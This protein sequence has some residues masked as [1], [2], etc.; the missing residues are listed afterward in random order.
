MSGR[1]ASGPA[2][3]LSVQHR[4]HLILAVFVLIVCAGSAVG[5]F[6]LSRTSDRTTELVDRIQPARSSSFQLQN[7]LLD[8]ETGVRGFALTGDATF[9]RP[10]EQGM[11][12]ESLQLARVRAL[13]GDEQPF[14]DDLDRIAAAAREWRG[15]HAEP[16]VAAVRRDGP[17][18]ESS[19]PIRQS[20]D[21]FDTLRRLYT[22]QQ[23]HLDVARDRARADLSTARTTR[24]QV[25]IALVVG[26][27]LTVVS[28]GLL[29]HRT[30]GRP[31]NR[32]T[33]ASDTVRSGAFD[34]RIEIA[35]P[36]DV[37]AV[38]AAVEDMRRR[39]VEELADSR[40]REKLL[41]E[42]AQELRRS[43]AELE[44][45][46]YVASHDLQEPLR[47]VASFC[48][49]LEKRAAASLDD[50]ARQYIDYA[51]DGADRMQVLIDDLLAFSRVG[52]VH[53]KWKPVALDR[54]LDRALADLALVVEESGA[55]VVREG[56]LPEMTGDATALSMVWQNL[57][58]NAVK[59][60]RPDVPCRI[61]VGC[62]REGE[63]WHFLVADNGIGIAP[64][65]AQKVFVIFQ[66]LHGR[67]EYEGTG[68]GL[69]L[70]RKIVEF[71]GG[72]IWLDEETTEGT[73][74]RFTLP[75]TPDV[76]A[77]TAAEPLVTDPMAGRPGHG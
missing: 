41:A 72:R 65:S 44:Q 60:S 74:I 64:E 13:V 59:F 37:R 40:E 57:I 33:A 77:R 55:T 10:Y 28:L 52:R 32:L 42:Q 9:L 50:R 29:L 75:V 68:I 38:A 16:L 51:V 48:R 43:N 39:I 2:S 58:G 15:R 14:A 49:L 69:A 66:R 6:V 76:P 45:F 73:R 4:V 26:F 1:D 18:S 35:G 7:A 70:C 53:D 22:A 34:S 63:D 12:D 20:K 62:V 23:A 11:R 5:G 21:E 67:D 31:L 36:S 56:P 17:A 71:H 46:A 27:L 61:S 54:T 19:V 24:D 3:R 47:K 25:L 8:Q 30:V